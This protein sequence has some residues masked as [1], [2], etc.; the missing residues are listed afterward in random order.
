MSDIFLLFPQGLWHGTLRFRD[1]RDSAGSCAREPAG[2]EVTDN[3][4]QNKSRNFGYNLKYNEKNSYS[5]H[6]CLLYNSNLLWADKTLKNIYNQEFME[7][8]TNKRW[9]WV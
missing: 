3:Y 9:A 5:Y 6:I 2:T 4:I 1:E 8:G 7:I